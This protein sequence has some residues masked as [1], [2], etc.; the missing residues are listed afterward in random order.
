MIARAKKQLVNALAAGVKRIECRNCKKRF[1]PFAG[2]ELTTFADLNQEVSCPQCGKP[3]RLIGA[4]AAAP[5]GVLEPEEP[6]TQP[7]DSRIERRPVSE[8]E[9]LFYLPASGTWG[10]WLFFAGFWNLLAWP[11]FLVVAH[12]C[13]VKREADLI[14]LLVTAIF[15]IIGLALA[16]TALRTRFATHLLYLG[17]EF[18]RL[19]RTLFARETNYDLP[20]AEIVHVKQAEFYRQNYRPVHGIEISAGKRRIRFGSS[21]SPDEKGWLCHEIRNFVRARGAAV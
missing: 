14:T 7:R 15:P 1:H 8:H 21:L 4:V 11:I 2:R 12:V 17:P 5:D 3:V 6:M 19:Q 16:Y 13:L 9:V 18:V 20:T 10:V